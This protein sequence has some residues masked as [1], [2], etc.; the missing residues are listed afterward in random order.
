MRFGLHSVE[1]QPALV[2]CSVT[3]HFNEVLIQCSRT[4][5]IFSMRGSSCKSK[6]LDFEYY[7]DNDKYVIVNNF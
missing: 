6:G 2:V 7:N 3:F 4:E 1:I 5:I